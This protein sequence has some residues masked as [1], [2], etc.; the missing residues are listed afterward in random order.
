M[1][2]RHYGKG[3]TH[4]N[5]KNKHVPPTE[6]NAKAK[7]SSKIKMKPKKTKEKKIENERTNNQNPLYK[8]NLHAWI[9]SRSRL[10]QL[11][12]FCRSKDPICAK[13]LWQKGSDERV[14]VCLL[15]SCQHRKDMAT[16]PQPT[17]DLR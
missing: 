13:S 6:Q 14:N 15:F 9:C 10:L 16:H 17:L 1:T 11:T 8:Y 2:H 3:V 5:A 12:N 7:T 4:V